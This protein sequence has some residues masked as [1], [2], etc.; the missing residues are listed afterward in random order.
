MTRYLSA[1]FAL[2]LFASSLTVVGCSNSG[3]APEPETAELTAEDEQEMANYEEEQKRN[4]ERM[5]EMSQ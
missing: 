2:C 3:P 4:E 1:F 5:R